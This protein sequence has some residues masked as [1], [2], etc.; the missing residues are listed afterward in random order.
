MTSNCLNCNAKING[1]FC[2]NC[3]QSSKTHKINLHYLWHD[4]QHGL[5]HFDKGILYT[6]KEL[7]ARPGNSIREFLDGKRVNHFKPISLVII[8]AGIYSLLSHF[9]HLNLFSNYYEM[10]GSGIGYNEFKTSVDKLS[11]WLSQ[12][13]SILTL[14]QIPVFSIGTYLMFKKEG[15]NFIEHLV[16]NSFIAGQKLILHIVTFPIYFWLNKT[17]F[18]RPVDQLIDTIGYILAFWTIFQLF[19]GVRGSKRIWKTLFSL[20]IS[21]LIFIVMFF[22][23]VTII[24]YSFK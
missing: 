5:L 24:I 13:Y 6:T 20:I 23:I 19:K 12:H 18:S 11:E 9:F 17:T 3:G 4:I 1:Q 8:L 10:K 7:F 16:T 15:Y 22:T 14:L 21:L 2:S